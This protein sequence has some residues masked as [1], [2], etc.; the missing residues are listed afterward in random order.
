MHRRIQPPG[1]AQAQVGLLPSDPESSIAE[2]KDRGGHRGL[3]GADLYQDRP[4]VG[5]V[6]PRDKVQS[7]GHKFL[8]QQLIPPAHDDRIGL[9]V[10]SHH[11]EG[12]A[13]QPQA[14]ALADGVERQTWCPPGLVRRGR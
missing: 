9:G 1:R 8:P 7:V 14:V 2:G 3:A 11:V 10:E 12:T 4:F 6:I 5:Q 13:R